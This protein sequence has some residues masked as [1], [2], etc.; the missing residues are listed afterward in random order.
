LLTYRAFYFQNLNLSF[1]FQDFYIFI[2]FLFFVLHCLVSVS[3]LPETTTTT[4]MKTLGWNDWGKVQSVLLL[5]GGSRLHSSKVFYFFYK[6]KVQ[7]FKL[8]FSSNHLSSF[9]LVPSPGLLT[10][11]P[12]FKAT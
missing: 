9:L 12:F 7:Y 5:Q 8:L 11:P 3:C 2:K 6:F 4:K 1:F 10:Y